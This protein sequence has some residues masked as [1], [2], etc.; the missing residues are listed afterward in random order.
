VAAMKRLFDSLYKEKLKF[1]PNDVEVDSVIFVHRLNVLSTF[2]K[3]IG[4]DAK[5][6]KK[7]ITNIRG[8]DGSIKIESITLRVFDDLR[9]PIFSRP[10]MKPEVRKI[11]NNFCQQTEMEKQELL[12]HLGSVS[13]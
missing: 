12:Y 10:L 1:I 4:E 7:I 8:I 3:K 5:H 13:F 2:L 9:N 11:L 6:I